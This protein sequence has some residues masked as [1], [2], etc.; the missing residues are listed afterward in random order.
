MINFKI[1]RSD[2]VEDDTDIERISN[3][4]KLHFSNNTSISVDLKYPFFLIVKEIKDDFI[5]KNGTI[6]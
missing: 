5:M 1:S 2:L 4:I 3:L 6:Y